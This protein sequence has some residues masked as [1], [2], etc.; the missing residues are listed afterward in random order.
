MNLAKQL[1]QVYF[2]SRDNNL[3]HVKRQMMEQL[4]RR[5][6]EEK[7]KALLERAERF[8]SH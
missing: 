1:T 5:M 4:I 6:P 2:A 7:K 8:K 3:E